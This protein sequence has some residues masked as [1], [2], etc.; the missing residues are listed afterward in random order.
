MRIT[1]TQMIKLIVDYFQTHESLRL[2]NIV[3]IKID[4]SFSDHYIGSF[5]DNGVVRQI[6]M[7]WRYY[8]KKLSV[9]TIIHEF[10]VRID[11][12]VDFLNQKKSDEFRDFHCRGFFHDESCYAFDVVFDFFLSIADVESIIFHKFITRTQLI[13][14]Q[15]LL[16]NRFMFAYI[17]A[18]S[19][20]KFHMIE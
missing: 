18:K 12:I 13:V 10:F 11:V 20:L 5:S 17:L 6:L 7:K 16:E 19:V 4:K 1:L 2:F 9:E 14:D 3:V 15:P 8:A